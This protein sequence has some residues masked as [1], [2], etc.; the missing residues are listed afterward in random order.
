MSNKFG[1][2]SEYVWSYLPY[3]LVYHAIFWD[4]NWD[5]LQLEIVYVPVFLGLALVNRLRMQR[6]CLMQ[7]AIVM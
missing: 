2:H 5:H 1:D 7:S 6:L 4:L 3:I